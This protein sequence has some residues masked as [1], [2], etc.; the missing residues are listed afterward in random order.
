[1]GHEFESTD[2]AEVSATPEQV[3][4]A[5]ATGP[6]IDSWYMGSNEVDNGVV[7]MAFGDYTP[8]SDITAWDP[9]H[10]FRYAA[11]VEPDGR[12]I[13]YEF[14]VQGRDAGSTVLRLVTSGFLPGDDWA[15]E[16]EAMTNGGA[17][18]F[19]TLRT[20]LTHFA[21]RFATPLTVFGPMVADWPSAWETLGR[22]MNLPGRP[23]TGDRVRFEAEGI[24]A[25]D[26]EVYFANPQTVGVR[27]DDALYR[28]LQG[29]HGP[30][31]AGHHLFTDT[32]A[33]AATGAWQRWLTTTLENGRTS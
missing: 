23:A 19:A 28:F 11:P 18:F 1:M 13:A 15:D 12:F 17:L 31:I 10:R 24:G 27:T 16:F 6:G 2:S 33:T 5:I 8:E 9:P 30:M 14:L 3:W 26:G 4:D 22:A 29:F 7:R 20:Y 32:D 21:G 25:I